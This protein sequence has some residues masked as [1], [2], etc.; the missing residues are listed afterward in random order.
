M[1][2]F[3]TDMSLN[4]ALFIITSFS[5]PKPCRVLCNYKGVPQGRA[6]TP[7]SIISLRDVIQDGRP[8]ELQVPLQANK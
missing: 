8:E 5:S 2:E 6:S 7:A 1:V 4:Y 3:I